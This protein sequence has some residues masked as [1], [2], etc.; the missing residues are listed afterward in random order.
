VTG[1]GLSRHAQAESGSPA[2]PHDKPLRPRRFCGRA[3]SRLATACLRWTCTAGAPPAAFRGASRAGPKI[4]SATGSRPPT[5]PQI[6]PGVERGSQPCLRWPGG[7]RL[8]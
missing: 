3:C 4:V 7:H 1:Q 5:S 6:H 8:V 2:R